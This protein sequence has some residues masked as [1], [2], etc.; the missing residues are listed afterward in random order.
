[1]VLVCLCFPDPESTGCEGSWQPLADLAPWGMSVESSSS[2][3]QVLLPSKPGS[4]LRRARKP[5]LVPASLGWE[6]EELA[7]GNPHLGLAQPQAAGHPSG[8]GCKQAVCRTSRVFGMK[9]AVGPLQQ[10]GQEAV[11]S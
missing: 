9:M 2:D 7:K 4:S 10:K 1:M 5:R 6:L 11:R 8:Q 3:D